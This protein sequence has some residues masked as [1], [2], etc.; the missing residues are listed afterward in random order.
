MA[1]HSHL[2]IQ[3]FALHLLLER[4]QRLIDI[5]VANLNFHGGFN[6]KRHFLTKKRGSLHDH[7]AAR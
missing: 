2:T 5:I 1:T 3:A 6:S 7:G 4:A